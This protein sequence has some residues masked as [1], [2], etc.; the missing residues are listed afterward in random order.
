MT[1]IRLIS[2]GLPFLFF[3]CKSQGKVVGSLTTDQGPKDAFII[4]FGSC[5]KHELSNPFWDDILALQPD[6]FIWG[7]DIVYADSKDIKNIKA[8]YEAQGLVPGY[9]AL[10][11][12]ISV[13]GTWDDHDYGLNDGGEEF[14]IK[15]E[16]QQAFLDFLEV[17]EKSPR[18][19]QT[20]IYS[21]QL[22]QKPSGSVKI[23]NLD[24]RFFRT[25]LT[26][27]SREGKRYRPNA[28]GKGTILGEEQWKWLE[29]QL[30][31]SNANFNIIVSSV[32]FLSNAHGF[33]KWGNFPHEVNRLKELI[34]A[35]GAKG[36]VVLSGD[37]HISEFSRTE[38]PKLGY[39][40]IDFTSSGLTHSYQDFS[41]EP[42]PFRVGEVVS[43]LSFGVLKIEPSSGQVTMRI[44]GNNGRVLQ[45]LKQRY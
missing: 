5:N 15:E 32:Q 39:P 26:K 3:G 10:K 23:I 38:I 45:E 4:A 42:N 31:H 40:L 2:I 37:R 28:Y 7:G 6:I 13:T 17:S 36:V 19:Q 27:D 41:G 21:S 20:G 43:A 33:E 16:S 18:R 24:T 11:E 8:A 25:P 22:L 30:T 12:K 29:E 9:L 35:S 1:L 14:S 34:A 44:M